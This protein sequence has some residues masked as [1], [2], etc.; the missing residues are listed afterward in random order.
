MVYTTYLLSLRSGC[1]DSGVAAHRLGVLFDLL[2]QLPRKMV[3]ALVGV[4]SKACEATATRGCE[5]QLADKLHVSVPRCRPA[6]VVGDSSI[7]PDM[8]VI[9]VDKRLVMCMTRS[10][11]AS[12]SGRQTQGTIHIV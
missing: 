12:R 8:R 3:K 5:A 10:D 9:T 7:S 11:C 4:I 2:G 1:R 6:I